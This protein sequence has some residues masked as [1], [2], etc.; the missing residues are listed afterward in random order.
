MHPL[1]T[2]LSTLTDD[3]LQKKFG[4]LQKKITQ[5]YRFGPMSI[6]P[7]LQMFVEDYQFEISRR[8][9]KTYDEMMKKAESSGRGKSGIID[10]S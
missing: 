10:I 7:Q 1:G 6:V 5:A 8:N 4:E 3:E 9:Q 2:D